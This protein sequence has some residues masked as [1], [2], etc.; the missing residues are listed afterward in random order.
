MIMDYYNYDIKTHTLYF[1]ENTLRNRL[2]WYFKYNKM[3]IYSSNIIV[4]LTSDDPGSMSI[5]GLVYMLLGC[6]M[7][8]CCACVPGFPLT[9]LLLISWSSLLSSVAELSSTLDRWETLP[10]QLAS[11]V[12]VSLP[13]FECSY[14]CLCSSGVWKREG[15]RL[16][17][18]FSPKG[19]YQILSIMY[20]QILKSIFSVIQL[21][22]V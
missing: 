3:L 22:I 12:S 7:V 8:M 20:I 13:H 21:I 18:L 6:I 9:H 10:V 2:H 11:S 15:S 5:F 14:M 19:Y 16:I 4:S 17:N 1:K